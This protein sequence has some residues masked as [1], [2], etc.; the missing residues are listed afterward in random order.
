VSATELLR[1]ERNALCDTFEEVGPVAPTLCEGWDASDLAAHLVVRETRPDA[2]VGIVLP[3]PF[4][5]HT[6]N[7]MEHVK[8]R[9]YGAMVDALR[10]GPPWWFRN[11]P[12]AAPNVVENWIHH[13]DL[14]RARGDGP[15]KS[16]PELDA[17]LWRS[18]GFSGRMAV[19]RVHGAG[20]ELRTP[21]GRSRV[22]STREPKVVLTGEPGE[23]VLYL[24]GRKE[25]AVVDLDGPPDAVAIVIAARFGL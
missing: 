20:L 11:G 25:A 19:R 12:M 8:R 21:D 7:V 1:T 14:R 18:L 16:E 24:S 13:E 4:A 23:L 9:G 2:G 6:E 15:R 17:S 10:S 22:L 5:R 3:G